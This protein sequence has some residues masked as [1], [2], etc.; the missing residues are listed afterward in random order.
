VIKIT[1]IRKFF[2]YPV[3]VPVIVSDSRNEFRNVLY[4]F[5]C[6]T[7]ATMLKWLFP[8]RA[9]E[10]V[11]SDKATRLAIALAGWLVS[12][13]HLRWFGPNQRFLHQG[14]LAKFLD[15]TG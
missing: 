6:H 2:R 7:V 14:A 5:I 3:A 10:D 12:N 13:A 8:A 1:I 9:L 11:I 4:P 15:K